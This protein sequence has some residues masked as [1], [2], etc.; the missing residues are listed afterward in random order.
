MILSHMVVF[1]SFGLSGVP[2]RKERKT[3]ALIL[4]GNGKEARNPAVA[5]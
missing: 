1:K 4:E 5:L 3:I 2:Y